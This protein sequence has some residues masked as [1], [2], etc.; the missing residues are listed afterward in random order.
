MSFAVSQVFTFTS[1]PFIGASM[2]N[3]PISS[4]WTADGPSAPESATE[5]G[6]LVFLFSPA[7]AQQMTMF[8]KV[9]QSFPTAKQIN[10]FMSYYS[11]STSGTVLFRTRSYLI[12]RGVDSVDSV[13]NL[14]TSTNT[15]ISNIAT[16]NLYNQIQIDLT[17]SVGLVNATTVLPGDMLRINLYRDTDTDTGIVRLVSSS[18]EA[19]Y[20]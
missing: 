9:P 1:T 17:T 10:L 14:Y 7:L 6:E 16:S 13:T 19:T 4:D 5:N 3:I 20:S 18:T 11:P 2:T 8:V 15:A 12:R